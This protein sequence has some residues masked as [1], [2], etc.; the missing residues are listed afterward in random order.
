MIV[1]R[2][3]R[4]LELA[5]RH[6][7]LGD[8]LQISRRMI[9]TGLIGGKSVGMLLARAILRS[10]RSPLAGCARSARFVLHRI[11]RV[12]LVPGRKRLLVAAAEAA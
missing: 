6:F 11:G 2:D 9:G 5:Q 10:R 3:E 7:D 4:V 1:S 8:V 12:L